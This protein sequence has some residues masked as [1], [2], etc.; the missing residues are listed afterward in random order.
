MYVLLNVF[1]M[2]FLIIMVIWG[3]NFEGLIIVVF[4]VV[5]VL[6]RGLKINWIG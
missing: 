3:V 6:M 5:I 2:M 1:L 4:L